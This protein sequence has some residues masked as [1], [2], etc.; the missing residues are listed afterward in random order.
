VLWALGLSEKEEAYVVGSGGVAE[1]VVVAGERG[2]RVQ[3]TLGAVNESA[4]R[5]DQRFAGREFDGVVSVSC[6]ARKGGVNHYSI[7]NALV[8]RTPVVG[9]GG[10][11]MACAAERGCR[12]VGE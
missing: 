6:D 8:R 2:V 7:E 12:L 11:S 1:D 3:G 4:R 9:T 5:C 10:S